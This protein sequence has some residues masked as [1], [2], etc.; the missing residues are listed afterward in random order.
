[1]VCGIRDAV[2]VLRAESTNEKAK[3][4]GIF[5]DWDVSPG[6]MWANRSLEDSNADSLSEIV[7]FD[8]LTKIQRSLQGR[9]TR[10]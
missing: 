1:M 4:T 9:F 10:I 5:H 6:M 8:V 2:K 7:L 3:L